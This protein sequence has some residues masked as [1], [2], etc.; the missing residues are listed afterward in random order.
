MINIIMLIICLIPIVYYLLNIR[1][2]KLDKTCTDLNFSD[3]L[4]F[5][6]FL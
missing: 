3:N 2:F 5:G 6:D 4:Q 1:K